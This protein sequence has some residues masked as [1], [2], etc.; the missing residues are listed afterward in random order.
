MPRRQFF[1]FEGGNEFDH[2]EPSAQV[3]WPFENSSVY[4][5]KV[6]RSCRIY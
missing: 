1:F 2:G 3:P 4:L 6:V 5:I